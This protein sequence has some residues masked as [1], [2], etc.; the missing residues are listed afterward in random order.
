MLIL[1]SFFLV[2]EEGVFRLDV[3]NFIIESQKIMLKILE[4][5]KLFLEGGDDSI[6]VS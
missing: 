6:F 1:C 2:K 5:E 4:L 3:G